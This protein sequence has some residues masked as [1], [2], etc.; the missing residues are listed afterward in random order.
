MRG[1]QRHAGCRDTDPELFFP[2]GRDD[3]HLVEEHL[4]VVRPIC[5]ACPVLIECRRW[6]LE[7][8]Q[9]HGLWAATTPTQR[10]QERRQ[11]REQRRLH[12]PATPPAD[13]PDPEPAPAAASA[14]SGAAPGDGDLS[15]VG[16][17]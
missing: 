4:R 7:T 14:G 9:E 6:A 3:S 8:G 1:W 16:R 10:R 15:G 17:W 11:A 2:T 13:R 12:P 5:R